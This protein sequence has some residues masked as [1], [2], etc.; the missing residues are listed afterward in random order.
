[1]ASGDDNDMR[2]EALNLERAMHHRGEDEATNVIFD[3]SLYASQRLQDGSVNISSALRTSVQHMIGRKDTALY[4]ALVEKGALIQE[5]ERLRATLSLNQDKLA[6]VES[7]TDT[8]EKENAALREENARLRERIAVLEQRVAD[9][10]QRHDE[11]IATMEQRHDERYDDLLQR[12]EALFSLV[13][14]GLEEGRS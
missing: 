12:H 14:K 13:M 1:M 4:K 11:R 2:Q 9:M 8:L 10:E 3:A 6:Y 7:R 5:V